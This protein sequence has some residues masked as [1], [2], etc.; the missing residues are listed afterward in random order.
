M[1][2]ETLKCSDSLKNNSSE[3]SFEVT[4]QGK[5]ANQYP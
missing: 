4:C 1:P 2:P 3:Y 5:S